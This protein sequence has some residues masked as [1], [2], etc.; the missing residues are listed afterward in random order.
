MHSGDEAGKKGM[1]MG[2]GGGG[3]EVDEGQGRARRGGT[4]RPNLEQ[5]LDTYSSGAV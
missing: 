3:G 1:G 5:R 2:G 4:N